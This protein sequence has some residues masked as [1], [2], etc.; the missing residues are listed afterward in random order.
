MI[1]FVNRHPV[2]LA[3]ACAK[4]FYTTEGFLVLYDTF[5][6]FKLKIP[7]AAVKVKQFLQT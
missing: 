4:L 1:E 6:V 2:D 5:F 3:W 7:M